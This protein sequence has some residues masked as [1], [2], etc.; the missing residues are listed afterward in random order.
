MP[1]LVITV[2]SETVTGAAGGCGIA[3]FTAAEEEEAGAAAAVAGAVEGD[4]KLLCSATPAANPTIMY[5]I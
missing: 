5:R 4:M 1:P 2:M 3:P